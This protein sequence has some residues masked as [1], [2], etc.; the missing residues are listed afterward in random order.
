MKDPTDLEKLI[1]ELDWNLLRT[2]MFV[3]QE[4]SITLAA[5][6][7]MRQ[8][9]SVSQALKR[10]ETRLGT[11]LID[12]SPSHFRI[13]PAGQTLYQECLG[14]F[15]N[16]VRTIQSTKGTKDVVTGT[17]KEYL[18][19]ADRT[20]LLK[21][22]IERGRQQSEMQS[23]DPHLAELC[24]TGVISVEVAKQAASNP[25]EFERALMIE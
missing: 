11:Q 12:R 25:D 2:F 17:V 6:R 7:L 19:D 5:K 10:L 20:T 24:T 4:G 3:V 8:Q 21:D 13:T 1:R 22:V 23:F 15:G 18:R 14:I 9:P 16:L